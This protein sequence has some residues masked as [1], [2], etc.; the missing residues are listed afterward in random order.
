MSANSSLLLVVPRRQ[1]LCGAAASLVLFAAARAAAPFQLITPAEAALPPGKLP[2]F[3]IRGSP[4]RLPRV[5][6]MSPPPGGGA[7]YS[8]LDFKLRFRAFGGA[9]INPNLVVVT[10]VK[11]PDIDMT[12]R[13]KP[14][15]TASGIDIPLAE[16]PPGLHQ[17]WIELM[18]TDGRPGA[19][20]VAFQVLK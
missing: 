5:T 14:F 7:V 10:Y 15:I 18:D 4:T 19:R 11:K 16:V 8:P 13:I 3:E 12:S 20:A 17:F 1:A 2:S 9:A 6:M